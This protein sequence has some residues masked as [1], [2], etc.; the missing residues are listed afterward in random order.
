MPQATP[1]IP[2]TTYTTGEVALICGVSPSKVVKWIDNGELK[3]FRIPGTTH[4]RI[5]QDELVAF[6][7][8]HDYPESRIQELASA[9]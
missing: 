2:T 9:A 6:M 7:R 4:R 1:T 8:Q 5:W 3:G